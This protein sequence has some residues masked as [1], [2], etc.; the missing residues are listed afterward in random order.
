MNNFIKLIEERLTC[1]L[2][3]HTLHV[4]DESHLHAGHASAGP[5]IY[6]ICVQIKSD[7][8]ADKSKIDQ[9]KLIYR[10]LA[11]WMPKPLHAVRIEII[12]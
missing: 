3:P 6:H 2:A 11:S 7:Q 12:D 1:D 8:L 10:S 9:H 5:G 4:I